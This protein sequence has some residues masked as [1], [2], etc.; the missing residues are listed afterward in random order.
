MATL[1]H[2]LT[3]ARKAFTRSI[4]HDNKH[5]LTASFNHHSRSSLDDLGHIR[6]SLLENDQVRTKHTEFTYLAQFDSPVT[7]AE[8]ALLTIRL[9]KKTDTT[10]KPDNDTSTYKCSDNNIDNNIT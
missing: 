3:S 1:S 4:N 8:F 6:A 2:S 5:S 10:T 7:L 9:I